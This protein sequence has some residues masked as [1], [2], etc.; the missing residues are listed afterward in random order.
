MLESESIDRGWDASEKAVARGGSCDE[1]R[2]LLVEQLRAPGD[3]MQTVMFLQP[4]AA[5]FPLRRDIVP[6]DVMEPLRRDPA[7]L[8]AL[9]D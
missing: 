8:E 4:S 3:S 9:A 6:E 1:A 5:A 2:D 7:V